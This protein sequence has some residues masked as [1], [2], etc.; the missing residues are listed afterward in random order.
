MAKI[1]YNTVQKPI[2]QAIIEAACIYWDIDKEYFLNKW[3][4]REAVYR[5]G[6]IYYLLREKTTYSYKVYAKNLGFQSH[7]PVIRAISKIESL[8]DVDPQCKRDIETIGNIVEKLTADIIC[9][10]IRLGKSRI[11]EGKQ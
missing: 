1:I 2:E 5:K 10:E 7:Q 6:I 8:K 3:Q 11:I 9:L 4:Q